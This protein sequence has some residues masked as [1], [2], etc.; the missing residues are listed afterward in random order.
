MELIHSTGATL[1]EDVILLFNCQI[2]GDTGKYEDP[3]G[4][5]T[6]CPNH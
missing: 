5:V 2:C 6:E 4:Y 1:M 3:E